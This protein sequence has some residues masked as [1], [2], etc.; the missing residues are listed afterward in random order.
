MSKLQRFPKRERLRS[1]LVIQHIFAKNTTIKA[2][3]LIFIYQVNERVQRS[4]FLFSVPKRR[5]SKAHERNYIKR[6]MKE[7]FRL[8]KNTLITGK[9]IQGAFVY[10]GKLPAVFKDVQKSIKIIISKLNEKNWD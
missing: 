7:N 6:I 4:Q 5:V 8:Q 1:K 10:T 9:H 3:P 2:F